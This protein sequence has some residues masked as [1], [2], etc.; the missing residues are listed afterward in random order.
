MIRCDKQEIDIVSAFFGRT[1]RKVCQSGLDWLGAWAW[2]VNCHAGNALEVTRGECQGLSS[3]ELNANTA[4][5][6]EPCFG[7]KKYLKVTYRC[8]GQI[9]AGDTKRERV[10]E[11]Q[12]L[13][14]ECPE[15][16]MIDIVWANFG[17]LKGSHVC[18]DGFFGLFSWYQKCH[19]AN[20]LATVRRECQDKEYCSLQATVSRFGDSCWG[21][22]KYLEV[23]YRCCKKKGGC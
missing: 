14:I 23:R 6:G 9:T 5:Y 19:N 10:C 17:R 3:C 1:D 11:N 15:K 12:H 13:S 8:I 4:E 2:N 22:K 20:S 7:T 21:T 16:R 18:G